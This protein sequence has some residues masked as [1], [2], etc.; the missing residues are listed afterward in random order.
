MERVEFG[1]T[2]LKVSRLAFGTGY[3]NG[4]VT[5]G[6]SSGINDGASALLIIAPLRTRAYGCSC[7]NKRCQWAGS[8]QKDRK[9]RPIDSER[10]HRHRCLKAG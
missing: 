9:K 1:R 4:S 5:A 7:S 10:I 3:L 6:N 8:W 2:G